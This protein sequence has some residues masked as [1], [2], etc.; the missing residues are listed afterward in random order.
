MDKAYFKEYYIQERNHWWF[1]AR[2][3]ILESFVNKLLKGRENSKILNVGVATGATTQMLQK[4]GEVTSLEYDKDCCKFLNEELNIDVI[5]G[6][7]LELPF[8]DDVYN[9][10][11]AFDVIEHV[12]DDELAVKEMTRVAKKGG[13]VFVTVPAFMDLWSDHDLINHHFRRYT[14]GPLTSL[15][16]GSGNILFSSYF[17]TVLFPPIYAVR[18]L[19][20]LIKSQSSEVESDFSKF[21]P[22][23]TNKILYHL[24]KMELSLLKK[25]VK[26][27]F[28]VSIMLISYKT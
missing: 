12:E 11:C 26:F 6:S 8:A 24:F 25:R 21:K 7:V 28:G 9:L 2:L 18:R 10:V 3:E 4:Y 22:G 19:S 13:Y 20:R 14:M 16:N 27:P 5:N 17:N 1:L 23:L 15:F